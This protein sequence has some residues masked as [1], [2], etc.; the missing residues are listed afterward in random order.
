MTE[1]RR[2]KNFLS[3]PKPFQIADLYS[4]H[5]SEQMGSHFLKSW[6]ERAKEQHAFLSCKDTFSY[7]SQV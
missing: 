5:K 6:T 2:K 1:G 3:D 4:I 7:V